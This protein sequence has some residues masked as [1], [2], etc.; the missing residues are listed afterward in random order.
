[1]TSDESLRFCFDDYKYQNEKKNSDLVDADY[2]SMF[3]HWHKYFNNV[4]PKEDAIKLL[5]TFI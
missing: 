5:K 2:E 3:Y 1:M 4:M